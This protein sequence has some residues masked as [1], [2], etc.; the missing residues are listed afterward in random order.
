[1][2]SD[3]RLEGV[4]DHDAEVL[5][6][7]LVDALVDG[8][9]EL[10]ER[11]RLSVEDFERLGGNDQGDR[12]AVPHVLPIGDRM[13][14]Q[15]RPSVDVLVPLGHPEGEVTERVRGDVDAARQQAVALLG[16]EGAVVAD[17][18]RDRI[19]HIAPPQSASADLTRSD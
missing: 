8:R 5:Q 13:T 19:G 6:P 1:M 15:Q 2:G 12:S 3:E 9:D 11:D 7:H 10:D 4:A 14:L 17:D 16:R 18:V